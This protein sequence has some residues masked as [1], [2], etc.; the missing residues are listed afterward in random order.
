MLTNK[1]PILGQQR[2][3][4][5]TNFALWWLHADDPL[6][7]KLIQIYRV[8]E[9]TVVEMDNV[10]ITFTEIMNQNFSLQ[11]DKWGK[12]NQSLTASIIII[13]A[14]TLPVIITITFKK[15]PGLISLLFKQT[16]LAKTNQS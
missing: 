14:T 8:M 10:T 16:E 9:S 3:K 7:A 15:K 2:L 11:W 12:R 6:L 1:A 13:I 5:K 4:T